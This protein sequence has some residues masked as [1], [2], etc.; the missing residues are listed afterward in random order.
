MLANYGKIKTG[1]T[2]REINCNFQVRTSS[3]RYH[4]RMKT[5]I[6]EDSEIQP[7]NICL[8]SNSKV[9][10]NYIKNV[11]PTLEVTLHTGLSKIGVT[12]I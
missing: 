5:H 6:I 2:K 8:W 11:E 4:H 9:V 12:Q 1:T 3:S 10:L 7:N